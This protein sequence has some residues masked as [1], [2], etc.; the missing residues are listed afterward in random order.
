M[1]D[2]ILDRARSIQRSVADGTTVSVKLSTLQEMI[3]EIERL[4]ARLDIGNQTAPKDIDWARRQDELA[5][6]VQAANARN[7]S[8]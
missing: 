8:S 1:T 6:R 2:D 3:A 5:G 4:R 7:K